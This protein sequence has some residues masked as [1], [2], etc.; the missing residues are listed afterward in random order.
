MPAML[1]GDTLMVIRIDSE[2]YQK[3]NLEALVTLDP[4]PSHA[5][6]QKLA[7]ARRL[8]AFAA[9]AVASDHTDIMGAMLL[10]SDYLGEIK[11]ASL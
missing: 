3:D 8:D 2:S 9:N 10:A 6:V 4:R 1:P 11:A 5:D 7:L